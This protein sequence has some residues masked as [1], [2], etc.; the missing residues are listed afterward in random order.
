[1][2]SGEGIDG[3]AQRRLGTGLEH[4]GMD[5][6]PFVAIGLELARYGAHG[7]ERQLLLRPAGIVEEGQRDGVA[8]AVGG[9]D[10]R[11]AA[12]GGGTTVKRRDVDDHHPAEQSRAGGGGADPVDGSGGQMKG[13]IHRAGQPEPGQRLSDA[14]ADPP[15]RLDFREQGVE[16]FGTHS[17]SSLR[18]A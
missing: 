3:L 9:E 6:L 4:F 12:A 10:P 14:G 15:E 16:D 1:M 17:T 18:A 8:V 13:E 11:R 7:V 5:D 2:P